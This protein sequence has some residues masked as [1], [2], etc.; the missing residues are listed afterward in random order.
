MNSRSLP[1]LVLVSAAAFTG[2]AA[3]LTLHSFKKLQLSDQFWSEG[4]NLGD[5]NKD[6]K[7][8]VVSGPFWWEGPDFKT[9]HEYDAT[10]KRK[11]PGGA[12]PFELKLGPM[13]KVS[14]PGFHGALGKENS[15]ADNFFAFA[16]DLNKDGWD[17]ILVL[18]F[19]SAA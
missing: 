10:D 13:T 4:A 18:G 6:G 7:M 5:F 3:D 14:V 9:R 1:L 17:D 11:S 12:A 19:P 16:Y 8:D 15:Y 2:S